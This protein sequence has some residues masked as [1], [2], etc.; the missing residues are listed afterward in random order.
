MNEYKRTNNGSIFVWFVLSIPPYENR[1]KIETEVR[2]HCGG[3]VLQQFAWI[4]NLPAP[5]EWV[6]TTQSHLNKLRRYI[7]ARPCANVER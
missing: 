6:Y 5:T 2:E 4:N 7:K 3:K 1:H